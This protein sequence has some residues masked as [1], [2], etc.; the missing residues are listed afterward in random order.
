MLGWNVV[1]LWEPS[2]IGAVAYRG[3]DVS[4][5]IHAAVPWRARAGIRGTGVNIPDTVSEVVLAVDVTKECARGVA[6][7]DTGRASEVTPIAL[8]SR[9]NLPISAI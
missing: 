4:H 8:F 9:V 1:A 7:G 3:E 5:R 6:E 2:D